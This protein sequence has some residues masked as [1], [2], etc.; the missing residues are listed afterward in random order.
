MWGIFFSSTLNIT[1]ISNKSQNLFN[2]VNI[3]NPQLVLLYHQE[4]SRK[5]RI[6]DYWFNSS[7]VNQ[8]IGLSVS[9]QSESHEER[10]GETKTT[11]DTIPLFK[12]S[13]ATEESP[14]LPTEASDNYNAPYN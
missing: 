13:I 3:I 14:D 1:L 10:R 4:M 6:L 12:G 11:N 7:V 9:S 2:V 5:Y 8:F